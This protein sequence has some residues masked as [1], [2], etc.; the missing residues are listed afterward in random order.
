MI[1]LFRLVK[2][3]NIE[4]I[5]AHWFFPQA[6]NAYLVSKLCNIPFVFTSHSSDV[7]I[8]E[9]RIPLIGKNIIRKVCREALAIS[10]PSRKIISCDSESLLK[11]LIEVFRP[12]LRA[13]FS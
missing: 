6:V 13:K 7:R 11:E 3:E 12:V 9:R 8:V 10:A 5:Y 1:A 2:R 4:L